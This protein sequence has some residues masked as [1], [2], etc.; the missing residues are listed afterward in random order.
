MLCSLGELAWQ[1]RRLTRCEELYDKAVRAARAAG[2]TAED[3]LG[4]ALVGLADLRREAGA[5]DAAGALLDRALALLP[6]RSPARPDA[7]RA[8]A[9]LAL[10]RREDALAAALLTDCRDLAGAV[11]NRPLETYARRCLRRLADPHGRPEPPLEVRPG[12]WRLS[13]SV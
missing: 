11:R 10:A 7:L 9:L 13:Q 8:A 6:E 5:H 2:G 4:R 12:V 3:E 1:Q